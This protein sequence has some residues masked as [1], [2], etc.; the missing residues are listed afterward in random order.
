MTARKVINAFKLINRQYSVKRKFPLDPKHAE[1][2][3]VFQYVVS[4]HNRNRIYVWGDARTGALGIQKTKSKENTQ[5]VEYLQSP[6][7][8]HFA[9]M[10]EII[11]AASGFGF[12]LF[13]TKKQVFGTGL[14]TDSQIG[15]HE[16]RTDKP[17]GIIFIPLPIRLPLNENTEIMKVSAGRAHAAA[18]TTE[19]LF[20]F[21]N[22][23]YGQ[24]G[25]IIVENEDYSR[26]KCY[27]CIR[28]IDGKKIVDVECGQDHTLVI[29]SDGSVYSCGWGADGQTGL[30]HYKVEAKFTKVLGDIAQEK[31]IKVA[32]R[33]DFVLALN[34]KGEVFGW[35]NTEYKQITLPDGSQQICNP[36]SMKMLTG[37]GKI[38]DISTGGSFCLI[39]NEDGRVFVWGFGLLGSGPEVQV[40][41]TPLELPVQLFGNNDFNPDSCVESV[42]CGLSHMAAVTNLGDLYSWGRN[43]SSCLGLGVSIGAFVNKVFCG[44]DH[45]VAICQSYITDGQQK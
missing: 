6:K 2:V 25:R 15:Y 39:V 26:N 16:I 44:L 19:G 28:D 12:T 42:S 9:E 5:R 17:L 22:N 32:C 45:T 31:I 33:S 10:N 1:E 13:A 24:C 18:L 7:R 11:S 27:D 29:L 8:L 23:S 14:N 34:D 35:G 37:L 40:S 30:G 41:E 3:S 36:I 38:K 21:G 4:D 20:M 43:R